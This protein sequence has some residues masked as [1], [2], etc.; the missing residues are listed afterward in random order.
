MKKKRTR[1]QS[2]QTQVGN[3]R[4]A[5][6]KTGDHIGFEMIRI[7]LFVGGAVQAAV[8]VHRLST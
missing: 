8:F 2:A 4:G 3:A 1:T 6:T 5:H 7:S